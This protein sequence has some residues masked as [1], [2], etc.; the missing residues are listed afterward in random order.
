MMYDIH[1]HLIFYYAKN[2]HIASGHEYALM[3]LA[4][5]R[6][7]EYIG[8]KTK[9]FTSLIIFIISQNYLLI[10]K[11]LNFRHLPDNENIFIKKMLETGC[12][13]FLD[14]WHKFC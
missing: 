10:N 12:F 9:V 13:L 1:N 11:K 4:S 5:H 3:R 2:Y 8:A 14:N 7:N 6:Y